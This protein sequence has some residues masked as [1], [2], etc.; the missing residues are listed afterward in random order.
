[1]IG[2]RLA[3]VVIMSAVAV[4]GTRAGFSQAGGESGRNI[5]GAGNNSCAQWTDARDRDA[6]MGAGQ[7]LLGFVSASVMYS[8]AP[9]AKTDARTIAS[10]VDKYCLSHSGSDLSDTARELVE[11]LI[12]GKQP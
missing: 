4:A 8:K 11:L 10:W 3:L 12:S 5:Y 7:W 2:Q 6:W 1:M 9:P